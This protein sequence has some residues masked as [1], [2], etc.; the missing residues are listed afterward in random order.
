VL[1]GGQVEV[2]VCQGRRVAKNLMRVLNVEE[3]TSAWISSKGL[4]AVREFQQ[5][6]GA[7]PVPKDAR[8]PAEPPRL[9]GGSRSKPGTVLVVPHSTLWCSFATGL[10]TEHCRH[11]P[12]STRESLTFFGTIPSPSSEKQPP[13]PR[14][15]DGCSM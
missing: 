13:G 14:G 10:A 2:P 8:L 5:L 11:S 6:L 3:S 7:E 1:S 12:A 9:Y 4:P 15:S